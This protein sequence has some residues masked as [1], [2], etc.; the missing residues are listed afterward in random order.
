MHHL[1]SWLPGIDLFTPARFLRA[2]ETKWRSEATLQL[3][4][5]EKTG[6][7]IHELVTF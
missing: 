2:R 5:T 3:N 1:V 7:A 6:W 4:G